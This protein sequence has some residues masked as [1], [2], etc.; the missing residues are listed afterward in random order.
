MEKKRGRPSRIASGP[1]E[2][3]SSGDASEP[4]TLGVVVADARAPFQRA[5]VG[6]QERDPPARDVDRGGRLADQDLSDVGHAERSRQR[7]GDALEA[8]QSVGRAALARQQPLPLLVG[9]LLRSDVDDHRAH[10]E[11]LPGAVADRPVA[12]AVCDAVPRRRSGV[13]VVGEGRATVPD[14]DDELLRARRLL[15]EQIDHRVPDV[16]FDRQPVDRSQR[17]VDVHVSELTVKERQTDL[18][19][20]DERLQDGHILPDGSL[21]FGEPLARLVLGPLEARDVV[22]RRDHLERRALPTSDHAGVDRQPEQFPVRR[23]HAHHH[24]GLWLSREPGD[25]RWSLAG[26]ELGAVLTDHPPTGI[27]GTRPCG[28]LGRHPDHPRCR[29][30][31]LDVAT[32]LIEQHDALGERL[33]DEPMPFLGLGERQLD[34]PRFGDVGVELDDRP[35]LA[36]RA[37]LE[38]L[39]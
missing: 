17:I 30:I 7:R 19:L 5:P 37:A 18:T 9:L 15:P 39:A 35:R 33:D 3:A 36:V 31:R 20:G 29:R 1:G 22:E 25:L 8:G 23:S 10:P 27:I 34:P 2:T 11:Q 26:R 13:F 32:L 38:R 6:R 24:I 14:R 16:R 21:E 28:L 4:L 12:D